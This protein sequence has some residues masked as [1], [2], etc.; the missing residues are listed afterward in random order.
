[1]EFECWWYRILR[2]LSGLF[3][4]PFVFRSFLLLFL[5]SSFSFLLD[6]LLFFTDGKIRGGG[7]RMIASGHQSLWRVDA[8]VSEPGHLFDA[9]IG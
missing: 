7:R 4:L 2:L 5:L 1:M 8:L 9:A 3:L 6:F